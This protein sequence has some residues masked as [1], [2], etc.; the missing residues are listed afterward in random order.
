M[1]ATAAAPLTPR[2]TWR[3][4]KAKA[5]GARKSVLRTGSHP[6]LLISIMAN[7]PGWVPSG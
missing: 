3:P 7:D 5:S 4:G 6:G 1:A 2:R